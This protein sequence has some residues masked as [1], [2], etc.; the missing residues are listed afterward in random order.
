MFANSQSTPRETVLGGSRST[1]NRLFSQFRAKNSFTHRRFVQK[2]FGGLDQRIG[3]KPFLNH[4]VVE[5]IEN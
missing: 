1:C 4:I 5:Q 3:V 2:Q